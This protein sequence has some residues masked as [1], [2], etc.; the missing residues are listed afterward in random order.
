MVRAATAIPAFV[1]DLPIPTF[2]DEFEDPSARGRH[3]LP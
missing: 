2:K 1:H 3:Q